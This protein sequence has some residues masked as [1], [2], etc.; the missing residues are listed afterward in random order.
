MQEAAYRLPSPPARA[1]GT[2]PM[3]T[4]TRDQR[5]HRQRSTTAA[6]YTHLCRMPGISLPLPRLR[7]KSSRP[8]AERRTVAPRSM[9]EA[10]RAPSASLF[11]CAQDGEWGGARVMGGEGAR[12]MHAHPCTARNTLS[13]RAL[14]QLE[15]SQAVC[16]K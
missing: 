2:P 11:A 13:I 16:G 14:A 12:S 7:R 6:T 8:I 5:L 15:A 3:P 9:R 4:P 10:C 1:L